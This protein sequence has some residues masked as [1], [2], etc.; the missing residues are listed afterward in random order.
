MGW[1]WARRYYGR[2]NAIFCASKWVG[3]NML[4]HGLER[5]YY[6]PLGVHAERFSPAHRDPALVS[7]LQ[8]GDAR[9]VSIFFP[10]RFS[11]EKGIRNLLRAYALVAERV[12][13][14]PALVFAGTGPERARVEKA[15]QQFEHV[16]YL[17]YLDSPEE[18]ARWYASCD[19]AVCLSAFE[20]FGLSTAEAM[21]SGLAVVSA[22]AGSAAELVQES[23]CGLTV[24][25]GDSAA[26]AAA[27]AELAQ[28][29]QL[30][31]RGERGRA[32]V[33]RL[34]WQ[35]TFEREVRFYREIVDLHRR[36]ARP[37]PGFHGL[38]D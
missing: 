8:A 14:C 19:L 18:M 23:G 25:Y 29:G 24:P 38:G 31:A 37:D 30:R 7:E 1:W 5:I 9:R 10:H 26:L 12:D 35:S 16:R 28:E 22:D 27:L 2:F 4:R 34:T 13:P 15:A 17:G 36:G 32:H 3:E 6:T 33:L 20:T 11:E 21:A